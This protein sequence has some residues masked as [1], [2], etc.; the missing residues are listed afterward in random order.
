VE[1]WQKKGEVVA[2]T[3]DGINDAPALKKADIGI[4]IGS[5][6]EVAKGTA[7][8]ILLNDSFA[9]IVDAVKQ[10]RVIL[11]NIRKVTTYL[12][13]DSFTEIILISTAILTGLPLP[14][15]AAQILWVNLVEDGLPDIALA[16]EPPEADV[17]KRRPHG[18]NQPLLTGEMKSIVVIIG[19]VTNIFTLAVYFWLLNQNLDLVLLQTIIFAIV[20]LDSLLF[21][22]SVKSLRHN[23]WHIHVFNNW[24][25]NVSFIFG[26]VLLLA[27]VY[28]PPLNNLLGTVPLALDYWFYI[29]IV[30]LFNLLTIEA[31]KYYYIV[32]HQ[33][34]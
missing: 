23:I 29:I 18:I 32:R 13:A 14:I 16:F 9:I 25:L 20:A 21:V 3:G 24:L 22:F 1:A 4:A 7:D 15:T 31:V 12:I 19:I 5:G 26:V 17:M 33:A 11:D 28:L 30:M 34:D 8:L 10:G 2:M 27:A 6:T